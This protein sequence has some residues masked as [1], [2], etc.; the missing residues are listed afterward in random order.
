MCFIATGRLAGTYR[1]NACGFRLASL[2]KL[3]HTKS[4]ADKKTTVLNY[5][6][7]SVAA[8]ERATV[9]AAA[10]EIS[11]SVGSAEQVAAT[12]TVDSGE[13]GVAKPSTAPATRDEVL[14]ANKPATNTSASAKTATKDSSG[15][16]NTAAAKRVSSG[17]SEPRRGG[18][19][20]GRRSPP[21]SGGR[22]SSGARRAVGAAVAATTRGGPGRASGVRSRG[23]GSK[24]PVLTRVEMLDLETELK[25]VRA[26]SKVPVSDILQDVRQARCGLKQAKDELDRVLVEETKMEEKRGGGKGHENGEPRTS[27]AAETAGLGFVAARERLSAVS[28]RSER[29]TASSS[30][31]AAGDRAE[32]GESD[33]VAGG[34]KATVLAAAAVALEKAP[35]DSAGKKRRGTGG[36]G[37]GG[38]GVRKLASFVDEAEARLLCIDEKANECVVLCKGLGE[39]FGEGEGEDQSAHIFC[40]LVQ[41]LDLLAEAKKVEGIC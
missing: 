30:I 26:A 19:P 31:S 35:V 12:A 9:T 3:S 22:I 28:E 5:M 16:S 20:P 14:A 33:G 24:R 18:S 29:S 17:L 13:Q 23:G 36:P 2:L 37:A 7:R 4:H 32:S 38:P 40:T 41:F 8:K 25:H 11:A 15:N 39:F 10:K 1:G 6:V 27:L 21:G 34:S